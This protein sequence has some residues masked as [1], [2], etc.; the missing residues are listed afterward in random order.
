[1]ATSTST[2]S[3]HRAARQAESEWLHGLHAS[4]WRNGFEGPTP[5]RPGWV[6]FT[7]IASGS[8][9]D[10]RQWSDAGYGAIVRLNHDYYPNGTIPAPDGYDAFADRCA[11]FVAHSQGCHIWIIGNEPNHS[12]E[13]PHG[14]PIEATDY[15]QCFLRCYA[16]IKAA[17]PDSQVLPAPVAP[18][19]VETGDWIAYQ[20]HVWGILANEGALDGIALHTYTHQ[21]DPAQITTEQTMDPPFED[22]RY[23]FRAY[24]DLLAPAY[25]SL[26]IY[27]TEACP[28]DSGWQDVNNGWIRDALGEVDTWNQAQP[29]QVIRCLAF[30]RWH[31]PSQ[32]RW[33]I[34][35]K[36]YVLD[37][38]SGAV[39]IGHKW[40]EQNDNGGSD[41]AEWRVQHQNRCEQGFHDQDATEVTVPNGTSVYWLQGDAPGDYNRPEMDHKDQELGHSEVYEGRFS[42]TGFY[43]S[44]TGRYWLVTN[45]VYVQNGR[46]CRGWA[47]YMHTF[48]GGQGG[49]RC[50]LVDGDGPFTGDAGSWP[51]AAGDPADGHP[52]IAWGGWR[53]T[54][55]GDSYLP[56]REW[57]K[58]STPEI[59]PTEGHVRL[60]VQFNSDHRAAHAGGHWDVFTVEQYTEGTEPELAPG[61][62]VV[63][64]HVTG[65]LR[66]TGQ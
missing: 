62:Y 13:R 32:G 21:H 39:A 10:Y 51:A 3:A 65:T 49:A 9:G 17:Q 22:R 15:T 20:H 16:N 23:Q 59:V 18:W 5:E 27:I 6:I 56:D 36:S 60:V 42:A 35:D 64:L 54:Y 50:G 34:R 44:S 28:V 66:L 4:S 33:T 29:A 37:D 46:P 58:L 40:T 25:S 41:M 57:A 45:P 2:N 30:Y 19:N 48:T 11:E 26:P 1:M 61:E 47:M 31:D 12:Q 8:G 43:I 24:R 52:D 55:D 7:E 38:Y 53:G 63:D 14:I